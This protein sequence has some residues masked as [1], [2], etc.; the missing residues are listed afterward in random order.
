M[1][2]LEHSNQT[3]LKVAIV[4]DF[5]NNS[6]EGMRTLSKEIFFRL[7]KNDDGSTV[8]NLQCGANRLMSNLSS[9]LNLKP[10]VIHYIPG[11]TMK[12][13]LFLRVAK[14]ILPKCITIA[15]ATRP[16]FS[17]V[18]LKALKIAKPDLILTQDPKW[19]AIFEA[20]G[21]NT[22]KFPNG[23]DLSR[24]R[25]IT[26]KKKSALKEKWGLPKGQKIL[27][28]V[29][30]LRENRNL[31]VLSEI[32]EKLSE[33]QIVLVASDA[34]GSNHS[35]RSHL[36]NSG[37]MVIHKFI[38]DIEEIYQCADAYI[39]TVF[40][41]TGLPKGYNEVGSIDMPLSVLEAMATNL[42]VIST[43]FRALRHYF[44][45]VVGMNWY[46]GHACEV[47]PILQYKVNESFTREAVAGLDWEVL[48][49][50]LRK[51]YYECL[52]GVETKTTRWEKCL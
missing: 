31:A 21:I 14:A 49:G 3:K 5:C 32:Q 44:D 41:S 52:S 42:P 39:F 10:D 7:V 19:E 43:P 23:V 37:V 18:S 35:L 40:P 17:R 8:K 4:G 20:A 34:L 51:V 46:N 38:P 16:Y 1:S 30:H 47:F 13:L 2:T 12:S 6:A 29:G 11:P 36:V 24:F 50:K 22:T 15:S 9:I 28:H 27:L 45:G 25:P 48:I 33:W 26:A